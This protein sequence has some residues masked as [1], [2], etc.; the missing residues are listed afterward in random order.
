MLCLVKVYQVNRD[1]LTSSL[2]HIFMSSSIIRSSI[3]T[4]V[5]DYNEENGWLYAALQPFFVQASLWAALCTFGFN[6][7]NLAC[8]ID[9]CLHIWIHII[10]VLSAPYRHFIHMTII[11]MHC[12]VLWF[13]S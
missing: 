7:N 8:S 13:I 11:P 1:N 4:Y 12:Y 9:I 5:N 3:C 10:D 6:Q 2:N